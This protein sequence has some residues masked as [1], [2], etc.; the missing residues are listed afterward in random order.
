MRKIV[1]KFSKDKDSSKKN[2]AFHH[3]SLAMRHSFIIEKGFF[4]R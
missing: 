3:V 2:V 1:N 4:L